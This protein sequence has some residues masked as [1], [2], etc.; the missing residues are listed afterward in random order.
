MIPGDLD[1][2]R[3]LHSKDG[4][5]PIIWVRE[6]LRCHSAVEWALCAAVLNGRS[7]SLHL[8]AGVFPCCHCGV[9]VDE[10]HGKDEWIKEKDGN[11][12]VHATCGIFLQFISGMLLISL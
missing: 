11:A 1:F 10:E 2:Q 9:E 12:K 5:I 7:P 8:D 3:K 6:T 4:N